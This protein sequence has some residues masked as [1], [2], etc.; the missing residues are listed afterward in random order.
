MNRDERPPTYLTG[1]RMRERKG[2]ESK[3]KERKGQIYHGD[4]END[5]NNCSVFDAAVTFSVASSLWGVNT[6]FH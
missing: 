2:E 5:S 1:R 4:K 6:C 3:G